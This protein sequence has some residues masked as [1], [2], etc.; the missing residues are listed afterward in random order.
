[1]SPQAL[2][3]PDAAEAALAAAQRAGLRVDELLDAPSH[4]AAAALLQRVWHADSPDSVC[5]AALMTALAHAGNYV[6]GAYRDDRLIG[7]AVAFFG[8]DGLH[9]HVAGV[10]REF[11][12]RGVGFA[13]KQHQRAW[14]LHRDIATVR[15]TY[16][17]L[18]ARNAYFNLHKLGAIAT[19][20]LPDF[21]GELDDGVNRGD[22]TDRLYVSWD[23]R[24]PAAV[25]AAAGR[26]AT[27]DAQTLA[28][29]AVLLDRV[30]LSPVR[31]EGGQAEAR[32]PEHG[33]PVRVAVPQDVETLR[34]TDPATAAAWR[35]AV[36]QA[37]QTAIA[38][39][40]RVDGISRDGFYVLRECL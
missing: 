36:R 30:G 25:A 8:I 27:V 2:R 32:M 34:N 7:V 14:A 28:A 24:S 40:Y 9:S 11:G 3:T 20:Y 17:P 10:D 21:Y 29:S 26:P 22:P 16:D 39:G 1:V 33:G 38:A 15:W 18:I 13:L 5:S 37:M 23:L 19:D 31:P 35:F 6:V 12:R 4:H